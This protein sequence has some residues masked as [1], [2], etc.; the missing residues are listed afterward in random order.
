MTNQGATMADVER[1]ARETV[2]ARVADA[3]YRQVHAGCGDMAGEQR[4]HALEKADKLLRALE[5]RGLAVTLPTP[6]PDALGRAAEVLA[7]WERDQPVSPR[8]DGDEVRNGASRVVL[9]FLDGLPRGDS[10]YAYP[11]EGAYIRPDA[12]AALRALAGATTP[13]TQETR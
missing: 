3:L 4:A 8:P 2:R 1:L 12:F 7:E 10:G 13:T 6:A 9:A 11:S 5:L